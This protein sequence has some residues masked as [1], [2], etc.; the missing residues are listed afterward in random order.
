MSVAALPKYLGQQ[1]LSTASPGMRFGMYLPI[2]SDRQDLEREL[3]S[4]ARRR[5]REGREISEYLAANGMDAT[6]VWLQRRQRNPLPHLWD[7]NSF[8][9]KN[10]WQRIIELNDDD[11]KAVE[12][13]NARQQALAS[14]TADV[15]SFSARSTAPFATGLGNEHPLE[16]GFAF[17]WPY[18]LPY[19]PGSGVKGVLRQAAREL[20]AGQ[21]GDSTWN[22]GIIAE[23]NDNNERIVLTALDLLFGLESEDRQTQHFRGVLSFWDVVPEIRGNKLMV[24]IMTPHQTHYYANGRQPHDS[25]QPTPIS[26]LSVPP[27]SG[28]SFHVQCDLPRLQRLAPPLAEDER[29]QTLLQEAFEHAF[30]WLG[31]GAKT[32]MGYGTMDT[33]STNSPSAR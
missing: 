19:L 10:A 3:N 15:L 9:A 27:G 16:N 32:T 20:I 30:D 31:F 28:F 21:W 11:R 17:L 5:S 6:I 12:A 7:K 8:A 2:W 29:W 1:N 22:D 13:L 23:I 26:F 33:A 14:A 25:G 24:E 18:G 4:R